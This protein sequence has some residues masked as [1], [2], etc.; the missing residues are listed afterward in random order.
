MLCAVAGP[1]GSFRPVAGDLAS[2][3]GVV[4]VEARDLP[5]NPFLMTQADGFQVACA[6]GSVWL[7]AW[8]FR[9]CV[10][11]LNV[12]SGSDVDTVDPR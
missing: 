2:C 4:L 5:L 8:V 3:Q 7:V 10:R 12:G 11:V 9:V 1:D 6:I